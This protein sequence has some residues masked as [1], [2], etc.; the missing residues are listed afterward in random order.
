MGT[1]GASPFTP[2]LLASQ[3]V[4]GGDRD[5]QMGVELGAGVDRDGAGVDG[6]Y[7]VPRRGQFS[8][9]ADTAHGLPTFSKPARRRL[10]ANTPATA[11]PQNG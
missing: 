4:A 9:A 6:R 11:S 1:H 3:A 7:S 5:Q 2:E 10:S 8:R